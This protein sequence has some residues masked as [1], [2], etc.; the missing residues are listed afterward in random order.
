MTQVIGID[1]NHDSATRVVSRHR[2][3]SVY[4]HF[5][6]KGFAVKR[7]TGKRARRDLVK[8]AVKGAEVQY[9]TGVGHGLYNSYLG[10]G[11]APVFQVGQYDA[12]ECNAKIVHLL[13]CLTALALGPSMVA[14]GSHAFF[15]YDE[16]F[17]FNDKTRDAMLDCDSE[18]DRGFADGLSAHEVYLR[19]IAAYDAAIAEA[20]R[21]SKVYRAGLLEFNRDHLC[22]PSIDGRYGTQGARLRRPSR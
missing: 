1:A 14:N 18:I 4:P 20:K 19:A 3:K 8:E 2:R 9:I 12:A 11:D 21:T 16:Y 17:T 10:H 13:S 6:A 15:G 5:V 7:F 22:A